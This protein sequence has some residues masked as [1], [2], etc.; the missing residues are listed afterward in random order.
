MQAFFP[1]ALFAQGNVHVIHVPPFNKIDNSIG[2]P[3][4]KTEPL[5]GIAQKGAAKNLGGNSFLCARSRISD[6]KFQLCLSKPT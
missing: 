3:K 2:P 6:F 4:N 1:M 5:F